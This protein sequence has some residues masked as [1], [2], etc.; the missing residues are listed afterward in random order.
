M[1]HVMEA[2]LRSCYL[3]MMNGEPFFRLIFPNVSLL[4]VTQ[5]RNKQNNRIRTKTKEYRFANSHA[6]CH[7]IHHQRQVNQV[8][9]AETLNS[10]NA[11]KG[12]ADERNICDS[13]RCNHIKMTS[14]PIAS[15]DHPIDSLEV[16]KF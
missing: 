5:K 12:F 3:V 1:S 10:T 4:D 13:Q 8:Y 14:A 11:W 2:Q 9:G 15:I 6:K 16:T 7:Y